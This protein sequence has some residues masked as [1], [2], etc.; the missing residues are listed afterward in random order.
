MAVEEILELADCHKDLA[1]D[2]FSWDNMELPAL[3]SRTVPLTLLC[4]SHSDYVYFI[5]PS[6]LYATAQYLCSALG[7]SLLQASS[8]EDVASLNTLM[9]AMGFKLS[10]AHSLWTPINDI[11]NEGIWR[12][13]LDED[14]APALLWADGEPNGLT[15]ENCAYISNQGIH[16]VSCEEMYALA[17]CRLKDQPVF[18]LHGTQ[19]VET[20]MSFVADQSEAGEL[21]FQGFDGSVI[22]MVDGWWYWKG[23]NNTTLARMKYQLA[24]PMGRHVW[25]I[26]MTMRN[27]RKL[28]LTACPD[29]HFTCNDATCVPIEQ[30]CDYK[31][32]CRDMSDEVNCQNLVVPVGYQK[33][34]PPQPR[35]DH[36]LIIII[37]HVMTV[38]VST[39]NMHLE[40]SFDLTLSWADR[41]IE[42]YNLK[43]SRPNWLTYK[44]L[45][46]LWTPLV[47]FP[48][49]EDY[50]Y[51]VVDHNT[52]GRVHKNCTH[53]VKNDR[54]IAEGTFGVSLI[55]P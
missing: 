34:L 2:Y 55:P 41:R 8:W 32:D 5:F 54:R 37:F 16:D 25:V 52:I 50:Q 44:D 3:A 49:A 9:D 42:F 17:L 27:S 14:A 19:E 35:G 39:E 47:L 21:V 43:E 20:P 4:Q 7:T 53:D 51:T 1:G 38:S 28:L 11:E 18:T 15:Y 29:G 22:L 10:E 23:P 6:V 48:K 46:K 36:L 26:K 12:S 45:E 13:S 40:L 30:H 31:F 24:Y 33:S